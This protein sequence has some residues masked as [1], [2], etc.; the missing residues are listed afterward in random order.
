MMTLAPHSFCSLILFPCRRR[1]FPH[2]PC[3]PHRPC[4]SRRCSCPRRSLLRSYR[5]HPRCRPRHVYL[6][7]RP[8]CP[9]HRRRRPICPYYR[10]CPPIPESLSSSSPSLFAPFAPTSPLLI[11]HDPDIVFPVLA[12][13]RLYRFRCQR[14]FVF[15]AQTSLCHRLSLC[16]SNLSPPSSSLLPLD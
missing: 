4:R 3:S 13:L 6:G 1:R 14:V 15:L 10:R 8:C 16:L 2:C 12:F 9:C 7:R 5:P 11:F